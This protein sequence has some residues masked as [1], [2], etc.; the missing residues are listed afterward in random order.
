MGVT[1]PVNTKGI[2][3]STRSVPTALRALGAQKIGSG[4][5]SKDNAWCWRNAEMWHTRS[6]KEWRAYLDNNAPRPFLAPHDGLVL[7][8]L[9]EVAD[10]E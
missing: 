9:A 2:K 6:P 8:V 1:Y 7:D 4:T 10:H 5:A 3:L